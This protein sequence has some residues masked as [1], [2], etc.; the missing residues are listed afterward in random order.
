MPRP[1]RV[2]SLT[3]IYHIMIRG[4]NKEIIFRDD[5]DRRKF[6]QIL[7]YYL[8]KHKVEIFA[9]C[10]MDNHVHFLVRAKENLNKFMQCIQTVYAAHFNK[11]Y[12]RIGH[13]FQDRFKSIPVEKEK[14]LLECVRYIHQNPVKANISSIE[15][16]PWSSYNEYIKKSKLINP[17]FILNLFS[18][19]AEIALANYKAYMK[20]ISKETDMRNAIIEEKITDN[21]A[22]KFIESF[23][24]IKIDVIKK[25]DI[26]ERNIILSKIISLEII[27]VL[28]ISRI[29]GID[30]NILRKIDKRRKTGG[31]KVV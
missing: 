15:D 31:P 30:R 14:Y 1:I 13:L 2:R 19:N 21:E 29:T 5:D 12:K 4:V 17:Q 18:S 6:L 11:K 26:I 20:I 9:Y 7:E 10:L 3:D 28:Q 8:N 25:M 27:N 22:I 16:Y 23:L 24:K